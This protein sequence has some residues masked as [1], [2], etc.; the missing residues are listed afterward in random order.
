M[1]LDNFRHSIAKI[2]NF[3]MMP[4]PMTFWNKNNED[5]NVCQYCVID[6]MKSLDLPLA[7]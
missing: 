2:T 1:M 3:A 6:R 7:G 5:M 4:K